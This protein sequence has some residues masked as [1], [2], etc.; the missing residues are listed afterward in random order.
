MYYRK[1][2]PPPHLLPFVECFFVWESS[3]LLPHPVEVESPPSG[4]GSM[5]FNFGTPYRVTSHKI[6]GEVIPTAFLTGQATRSY[7]LQ[8]TGQ[9]GMAGIVFR[10]AGLS[11]LFGLPMYEFSDERTELR[12]VLGSST[13]AWESQIREATSPIERIAI[14]EQ[15]LNRQ[16]LR[17]NAQPDRT[18]YAA[19]LI[20]AQQGVVNISVLMDDLYVCRR[21]FERQFLQKV[22]LSPKY[23][24]RIRRVG[25]L[26]HLLAQHR[27]Q[28]ADWQ[29]VVHQFGYYDQSH[30]IKEFTEFTGK[31][32]SHYVKNNVELAHWLE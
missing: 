25:A 23:Y 30:F 16:L 4:Y 9:V 3:N 29:D 10:P 27:W 6:N 20:V 24:A 32:P 31:S 21:Q 26:C 12:A 13:E 11:T 5:V 8:L 1:F 19:N 17:R 15:F 28:V 14:L 7:Q 2:T 18:D 22:G